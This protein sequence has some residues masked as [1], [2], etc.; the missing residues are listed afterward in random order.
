MQPRKDVPGREEQVQRS[1][2]REK[3]GSYLK[4]S[5]ALHLPRAVSGA[6]PSIA[7]WLSKTRAQGLEP[8]SL[9]RRLPLVAH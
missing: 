1:W 7:V 8:A 3:I 5:G 6:P 2:G 9:A 4:A